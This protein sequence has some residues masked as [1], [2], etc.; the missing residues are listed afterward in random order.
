MTLKP[1]LEVTQGHLSDGRENNQSNNCF[2]INGFS[3]V[4]TADVQRLLHTIPAK[5]SPLDILPTSLLKSCT[6]QFA[7]IIAR[8]ANLSFRDGQFPACFKIAEA[9]A[10][11]AWCWSGSSGELQA[12]I[13]PLNDLKDTR[14]ASAGTTTTTFVELH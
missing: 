2:I 14:E 13:Q 3:P 6:D 1:G 8:L 7:V 11:K 10:Q 4:T 9:T 5:S 12:D